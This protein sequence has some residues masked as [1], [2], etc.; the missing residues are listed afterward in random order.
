[1]HPPADKPPS[2]GRD[3]PRGGRRRRDDAEMRAGASA[4][5]PFSFPH[6]LNNTA[7]RRNALSSPRER[8]P[9]RADGAGVGPGCGQGRLGR[10]LAPPNRASSCVPRRCT[11]RRGTH[12]KDGRLNTAFLAPLERRAVDRRRADSVSNE[13]SADYCNV[14]FASALAMIGWRQNTQEVVG[15]RPNSA[16]YRCR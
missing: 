8:R 12:F 3:R 16:S 2:G 15:F 7:V 14:G 9:S 1:M 5:L 6:P 4:A 11:Q 13:W 10:I